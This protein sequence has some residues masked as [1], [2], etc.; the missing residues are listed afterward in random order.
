MGPRLKLPPYIHG[1]IDRH[2]KPRFYFR[3][4]GHETARLPGL[5][6]SPSIMA[7][8]EAAM[9][10]QPSAEIGASRTISGTVNAAVVSYY[11]S[12][13]FQVLAPET[14]RTRR[15][16]LERFRAE[17]ADAAEVLALAVEAE[18]PVGQ[19]ALEEY[20]FMPVT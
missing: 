17:H 6:Y 13:A 12:G 3:R 7:A 1:F 2:G 11:N 8:Y 9:G 19:A 5:P 15:C 16:I 20:G 10:E 14:K 18:G 4:R